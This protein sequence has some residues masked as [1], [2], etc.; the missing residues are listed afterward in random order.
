MDYEDI[1]SKLRSICDDY[2]DILGLVILFGSYSRRQATEGSDID[3]YIEPKDSN[4]TS[5][6]LWRSKRYRDFQYELFDN[7]SQGFD[8]LAYGGKR[9]LKSIKKSP[10][11]ISVS[12]AAGCRKDHKAQG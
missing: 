3:L 5:A 9:D 11:I 10:F 1:T 8:L 2:N 7:F 4:M 6:K 12:Y